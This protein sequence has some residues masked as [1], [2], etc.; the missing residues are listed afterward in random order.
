MR[1][2]C[3]LIY[4]KNSSGYNQKHFFTILKL[5]KYHG[6]TTYPINSAHQN[7]II[8]DIDE[9]NKFDIILTMGGDGT[10]NRAYEAF[11]RLEDKQHAIYGHIPT[12]TT[13]D[14][15]PNTNVPRYNPKKAAELLLHGEIEERDIITINDHAIAY[16]GATGIFAPVT[17]LIDKSKDKK[18]AGTFS[19]IRHG[20]YQF[21]TN[22]EIYK[23]IIEK[24]YQ[25]TYTADGET[26]QTEAIFIAVFNAKTFANLKI[27][28]Q[29][30]M[31]D[32]TFDV[33]IIHTK[34]ELFKL[35]K[36]SFISK[37]GCMDAQDN[38]FTTN[39]L[40]LT[41]EDKAPF[42]PINCDGDGIDLLNGTSTLEVKPKKKILQLTGKKSKTIFH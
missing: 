1:K 34:Q 18:D 42:Y 38:I 19:Y 40:Q 29:A 36:T 31:G 27:N 28:P 32:G 26:K 10:V 37:N 22:P 35:L 9:L 25:I 7:F 4:N 23:S 41:F 16:V 3:A 5:L 39:N 2:K 30:N 8:E 12:G 6:Y 13:N 21:F 15:G 17:Y 20:A 24:P 33:L 11:N 14:M